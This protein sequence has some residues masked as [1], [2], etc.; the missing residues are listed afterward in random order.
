MDFLHTHEL[1][2]VIGHIS[3]LPRIRLEEDKYGQMLSRP[4][5]ERQTPV[6]VRALRFFDALQEPGALFYF[7]ALLL[8]RTPMCS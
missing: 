7:R 1:S 6:N 5:S 3:R 2:E 8:S 4:Q